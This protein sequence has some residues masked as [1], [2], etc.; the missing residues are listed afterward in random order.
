MGTVIY[1]ASPM[2]AFFGMSAT[3]LIVLVLGIFG[4]GS[5]LLGRNQ[6]PLS[7]IV[8]GAMG[9]L[10]LIV[11]G[12]SAVSTL[13]AASGPTQSVIMNLHNK[14]IAVDNCNEGNTCTRYVL[15]TLSSTKAIDFN[16]P[17]AAYDKAQV[18]TCY[19][20]SFYANNGLFA[21]SS[22]AYQQID[23]VANIQAADPA[24]CQ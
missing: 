12:Y 15:E 20:F 4:V 23:S 14:R 21:D 2:Q 18:G 11:S 22:A 17:K 6:K 8:T 13:A 1:S 9:A 3:I 7:R 10:L 24:R 19:Q 16:V 5:A